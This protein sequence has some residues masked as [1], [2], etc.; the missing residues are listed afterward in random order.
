M[1]KQMFCFVGLG[2]GGY[3]PCSHVHGKIELKIEGGGGPRAHL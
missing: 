2:V 3:A 1:L